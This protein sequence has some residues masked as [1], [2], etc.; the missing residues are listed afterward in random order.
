MP[1]RKKIRLRW[2]QSQREDG[3]VATDFGIAPETA[4]EMVAALLLLLGVLLVLSL[5]GIGGKAGTALS[6]LLHKSF[7]LTAYLVPVVALSLGSAFWTEKKEQAKPSNVLGLLLGLV[8]LSAFFHVFIAPDNMAEIARSGQAGGSLGALLARPARETFGVIGAFF[9]FIILDV[10]AWAIGLNTSIKTFFQPFLPEGDG[11]VKVNQG[12]AVSVFQLAK[13]G[14]GGLRMRAERSQAPVVEVDMAPPM[15]SVKGANWEFPPVELLEDG[16][17]Q[18]SSGNITKNAEIIQKTLKEFGVDVTMGEVNVGPTVAQYTLK[19]TEGVKLNQIVARQNDLALSLAAKSLRIEAPIPGKAAVGVEVPNKVAAKVTLKEILQSKDFRALKS[20]LGMAIGRDVAGAPVALDLEKMPHVLIAGATGSGKSVCI[21]SLILTFLFG[22]TPADL[23]LLLVDPKRV[24]LTNYNGIPHLLTPVITEADKTVSAL[25]WLVAEMDRRYR[26]FSEHGRRNIVAYNESPPD[27][28]APMPRIV[29]V[30]DELADLMAVS[31]KEVEASIVRLAQMARA[32]G[33]HLIVAT[34]RPSV[35]V[36]TGLIKANVPMR[37][38]FA[39]ASQ[40]DS[41]TILDQSGADK[42]LGNGDMLILG[43]DVTK[44]RRVQG[45][46]TSDKEINKV[47]EFLKERS[48]AQYDQSITEFKPSGGMAGALG[49]EHS[50]EDEM[51][52]QAM[53]VVVQAGK[54][55]ASLLQRR[56]KVGYARAARLLDLLEEDGVIGPGDGAKP[57]DILVSRDHTDY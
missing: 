53:E 48:V 15:R 49:G 22:N 51:Y 24:E 19:P 41:R 26:T 39:V 56:L 20:P 35:D 10:V 7:G 6:S 4:R 34:Q 40:V 16:N 8:F 38:A 43:N 11:A 30:I 23:R 18:V 27:S 17:D 2:W 1:R 37:F 44:P 9:L 21:N 5:L 33:I 25:K 42:L 12:N 57:R 54:A 32:T 3:S 52:D 14:I 31:S 55:S 13:R 29:C 36:I 47:I 50:G 28:A 45:A 46:Y